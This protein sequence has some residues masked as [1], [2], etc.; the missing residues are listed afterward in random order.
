L[1]VGIDTEELYDLENDP[2]EL[3]NLAVNPESR[4]LLKSM[5]AKLLAWMEE[6]G[7]SLHL[8]FGRWCDAQG[9]T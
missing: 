1:A 2:H 6:K 3:T 8:L 7:D 5:R 9:E 4:E